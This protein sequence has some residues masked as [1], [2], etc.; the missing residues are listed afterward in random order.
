MYSSQHWERKHG[1]EALFTSFPERV[2]WNAAEGCYILFDCPG[3]V[4][5]FTLH[6]SL[7]NVVSTIMDKWHYRCPAC[8]ACPFV[9]W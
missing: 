1:E 8:K 3:Q 5:L 7:K 4:E 6:G 2:C 9:C